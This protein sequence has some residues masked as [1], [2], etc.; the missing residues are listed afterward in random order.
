MK[1]AASVGVGN[2]AFTVDGRRV[3]CITEGA[4]D[5]V[6]VLVPGSARGQTD[7]HPTDLGKLGTSSNQSSYGKDLNDAGVVVGFSHVDTKLLSPPSYD[8]HAFLWSA[9]GGMIDLGTLGAQSVAYGI[10]QHDMGEAARTLVRRAAARRC[11]WQRD[12][13]RRRRLRS[14]SGPLGVRQR[15][16][17]AVGAQSES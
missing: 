14:W 1:D 12:R 17:V 7:W 13:R 5:E 6:F 2:F 16:Y 9:G 3:Y 15:P 11:R 4:G 10:K 8:D